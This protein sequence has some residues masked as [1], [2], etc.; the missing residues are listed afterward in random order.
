MILMK[1]ASAILV[2]V[3]SLLFAASAR[4]AAGEE[5]C[6]EDWSVA[7]SI[8]A[9]EKLVTVEQL[10][11]LLQPGLGGA[12]VRTTLCQDG[13]AFVYKVLV[14]D[15]SGKLTKATIGARTK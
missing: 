10:Q 9:R 5:R 14:R 12:I 3:S 2:V 1:S 6:F 8:V 13:S 7:A 4:A 11:S 15:R